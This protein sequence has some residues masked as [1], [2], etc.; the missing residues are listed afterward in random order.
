M[1]NW[2]CFPLLKV[3][4]SSGLSQPARLVTAPWQFSSFEILTHSTSNLVFFQNPWNI[5]S[6]GNMCVCVRRCPENGSPSILFPHALHQQAHFQEQTG[7]KGSAGSCMGRRQ[8]CVRE[9]KWCSVS[10]QAH[11]SCDQD[12]GEEG[13]AERLTSM[14]FTVLWDFSNIINYYN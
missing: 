7:F 13:R 8:E 5:L 9:R 12:W 1:I 14:A 3:R 4:L 6:L 11:V 10:R 2:I